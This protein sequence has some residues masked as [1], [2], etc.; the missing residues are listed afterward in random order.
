MNRRGDAAP[1]TLADVHVLQLELSINTKQLGIF[2]E[3]CAFFP[4]IAYITQ[5]FLR[6]VFWG[7]SLLPHHMHLMMEETPE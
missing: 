4:S 3:L 2:P 5:F 1:S 6:Y 7:A